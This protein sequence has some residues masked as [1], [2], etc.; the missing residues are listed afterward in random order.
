M[1]LIGGDLEDHVGDFAS[2]QPIAVVRC[3]YCMP[4]EDNV[5]IFVG[6]GMKPALSEL[7]PSVKR[8]I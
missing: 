7:W 4:F 6:R 3:R 5:T 8:Y 2:V 1:I